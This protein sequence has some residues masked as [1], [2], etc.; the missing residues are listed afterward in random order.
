MTDEKPPESKSEKPDPML[1]D[2]PY[3]PHPRWTFRDEC[4]KKIDDGGLAR[5]CGRPRR[6]H[7][8]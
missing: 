5:L 8:A 6:E 2:H 1:L 4:D 3:V 7:P